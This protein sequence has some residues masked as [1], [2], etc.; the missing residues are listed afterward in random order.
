M[1]TTYQRLPD[2][3]SNVNVTITKWTR[4]K[5]YFHN[6]DT[7]IAVFVVFLSLFLSFVCGLYAFG[8]ITQLQLTNYWCQLKDLDTIRQHSIEHKLN[9]GTED[10]CWKSK[11]FTV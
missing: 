1:E 4:F 10:G 8:Q 11:Q 5:V 3:T 2:Y 6:F 7:V 9:E